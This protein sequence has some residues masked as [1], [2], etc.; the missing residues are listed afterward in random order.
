M[1]KLKTSREFLNWY[2]C[3]LADFS[4]L[5]FV[6][7]EKHIF[8]VVVESFTLDANP[9]LSEPSLQCHLEGWLLLGESQKTEQL[10]KT[11]I[12]E[13]SRAGHIKSHIQLKWITFCFTHK[14]K[15]NVL[16]LTC[17]SR[18]RWWGLFTW[19]ARYRFCEV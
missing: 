14:H 19:R 4:Q 13:C 15:I 6:F 5:S 7:N 11:C 3:L 9:S 10:T 1:W 8:V 12:L 2:T 17:N 16:P 18:F